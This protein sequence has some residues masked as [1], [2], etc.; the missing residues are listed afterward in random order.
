MR[1][2]QT[3][4]I[5]LWQLLKSRIMILQIELRRLQWNNK[6]LSPIWIITAN[7]KNWTHSSK[8]VCS[9]ADKLYHAAV[10]VVGFSRETGRTYSVDLNA[11]KLDKIRMQNSFKDPYLVGKSLQ[12]LMILH[13][14]LVINVPRQ[15]TAMSIIIANACPATARPFP[16][17]GR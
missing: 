6:K 4:P 11:V 10:N 17:I 15:I 3:R 13:W 8:V 9:A 7:C 5:R 16:S 1:Y 12:C 2:K 14:Y